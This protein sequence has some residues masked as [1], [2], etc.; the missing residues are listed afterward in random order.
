M[1]WLSLWAEARPATRLSDP[2]LAVVPYL[3]WVDRYNYWL[4]LLGYIPVALALMWRHLPLFIHYMVTS[5]LV[6]LL[7]GGCILVTGLGPVRGEDLHLG[8]SLTDRWNAFLGLLGLGFFN[9]DGGARLYLTKDLFFS[10]HTA[11]TFLL[12][13]YVWRWKELRAL[14]LVGHVL[15]VAS[16]F[17]AHLHY[18]IDIVGAYAITF[19]LFA[20]RKRHR[21]ALLSASSG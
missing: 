10:G 16:L 3:E 9:P 21:N 5:G 8:M 6:A 17:F 15:V 12:L 19:A 20:W 18:T 13:L 11:T 1:L 2:V 14:M 7:R 4:W